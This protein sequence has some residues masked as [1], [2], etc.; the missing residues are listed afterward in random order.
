MA[1]KTLPAAPSPLNPAAPVFTM[2]PSKDKPSLPNGERANGDQPKGSK[3][4]RPSQNAARTSMAENMAEVGAGVKL[5]GAELKKQ[6]AAEKAARRAEKVAQKGGDP[7]AENQQQ[8]QAKLQPQPTQGKPDHPRRTSS[9]GKKD[10]D[11]HHKR[12]GS[13]TTFK[14]LALRSQQILSSQH[15]LAAPAASGTS[16]NDQPRSLSVS[17]LLAARSILPF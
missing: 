9:S 4:E 1:D 10:V 16:L 8:Q 12:T 6:K 15:A 14:P 3:S 5:T 13:S 7:Q 2:A 17:P 11:L